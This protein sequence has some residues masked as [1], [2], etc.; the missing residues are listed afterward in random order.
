MSLTNNIFNK[1]TRKK[2]KKS[3]KMFLMSYIFFKLACLGRNKS[4]NPLMNFTHGCLCSDQVDGYA[5]G[6]LL[7][8]FY[9]GT[10]CCAIC[11]QWPLVQLFVA[12][13]AGGTGLRSVYLSLMSMCA[14]LVHC[15]CMLAFTNDLNGWPQ[16]P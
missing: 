8:C 2:L 6:M 11:L 9:F 13:W 10:A 1:E 12:A 3:D 7:F 15:L 16:T 5:T 14:L 4:K